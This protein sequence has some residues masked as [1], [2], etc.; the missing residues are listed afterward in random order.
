MLCDLKRLEFNF[1]IKVGNSVFIKIYII[2]L[3]FVGCHNYRNVMKNATW[4]C[5]ILVMFNEDNGFLY[6]FDRPVMYV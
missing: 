3:Y 2:R 6:L 5:K 4:Y 1:F